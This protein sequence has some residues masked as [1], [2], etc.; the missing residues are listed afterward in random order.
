MS[1]YVQGEGRYRVSLE[2][3][4]V[5]DDR[6]MIVSGGEKPHI[7]AVS[8]MRSEATLGTLCREGH[9]EDI[10]CEEIA[11]RLYTT[12]PQE[13]FLVI[14]GIHIENANKQEVVHL[15]ENAYACVN[16]YLKEKK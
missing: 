10:L 5:G 15:L 4:M 9:R 13:T 11:K 12:Y 8:L 3:H 7:G 14:G 2:V 6:L 1:L 16:Q